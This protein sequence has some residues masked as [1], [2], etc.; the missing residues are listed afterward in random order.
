MIS[1]E[2]TNQCNFGC[3]HCYKDAG[4]GQI[5]YLSVDSFGEIMNGLHGRIYAVELTGGEPTLHPEFTDIIKLNT[6]P[7]FDGV[8]TSR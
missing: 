3:T 6:T 1:I 2:L 8:V 7:S 4:T 5:G